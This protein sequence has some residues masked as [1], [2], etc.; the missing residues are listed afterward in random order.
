M[1]VSQPPRH[2]R[3]NS[4]VDEGH[5][6]NLHQPLIKLL[7]QQAD[8]VLADG[9]VNLET[10]SNRMDGR[11]DGWWWLCCLWPGAGASAAAGSSSSGG[12]I[13]RALVLP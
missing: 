12:S 2:E 11:M 7:L 8:G 4:V 13:C 6:S 10:E 1:S 9:I 5:D 3:P